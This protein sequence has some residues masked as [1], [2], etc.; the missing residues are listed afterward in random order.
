MLFYLVFFATST[1]THVVTP[2]YFE[3]AKVVK[4]PSATTTFV[5]SAI[6]VLT[7]TRKAL[8]ASTE[9]CANKKRR[10]NTITSKL[11]KFSS[12]PFSASPISES[13]TAWF[14]TLHVSWEGISE[15]SEVDVGSLV[16]SLNRSQK[17][18]LES[19]RSDD[20]NKSKAWF[21]KFETGYLD[22]LVRRQRKSGLMDHC[23]SCEN[24][25]CNEIW[26]NLYTEN[27]SFEDLDFDPKVWSM[28]Y[29]HTGRDIMTF[30]ASSEVIGLKNQPYRRLVGCKK[31]KLM[32][33]EARRA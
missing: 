4:L 2:G 6:R 3:R 15:A 8:E 7:A 19:I 30:M 9:K 28:Q 13:T 16:I 27:G 1:S 32:L 23:Q 22:S 17:V 31:Y 10:K 29:L 24:S 33:F 21:A 20:H 14:P 11:A 26:T 25:I 12:S 5:V 18:D